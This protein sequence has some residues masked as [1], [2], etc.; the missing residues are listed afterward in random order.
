MI[1]F[2]LFLISAVINIFLV[3]KY[4][5]CRSENQAN[6]QEMSRVINYYSKRLNE[7]IP[8]NQKIYNDVFKK[9]Y[10]YQKKL[11]EYGIE[12]PGDE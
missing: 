7:E 10:S 8:S 6:H 5:F 1:V 3:V 11:I 4:L 2:S 9:M 12:L